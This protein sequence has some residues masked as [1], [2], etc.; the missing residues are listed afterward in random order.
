MIIS[1][2]LTPT[3]V[4]V[5][6]TEI[7]RQEPLRL[8]ISLAEAWPWPGLI[9]RAAVRLGSTLIRLRKLQPHDDG[10]R[11]HGVLLETDPVDALI[12]RTL[13]TLP[14]VDGVAYRA[15][16]AHFAPILALVRR[17]SAN[18]VVR[19]TERLAGCGVLRL[20]PLPALSLERLP[21]DGAWHLRAVPAF[22]DPDTEKDLGWPVLRAGGWW[23]FAAAIAPAPEPFE[24]A[25]LRALFED[26]ARDLA[27]E[28]AL[29]FAATAT[30]TPGLKLLLPEELAHAVR[31]LRAGRKVKAQGAPAA[32]RVTAPV[33]VAAS[34]RPADEAGTETPPPPANSPWNIYTQDE[35][36]GAQ[37]VHDELD[38]LRLNLTHELDAQ[39]AWFALSS[40]PSEEARALSEQEIARLMRLRK[41]WL[42]QNGP[43]PCAPDRAAHGRRWGFGGEG[44]SGLVAEAREH[45]RS[46]FSLAGTA[47]H[48]EQYKAFLER[49]KTFQEVEA[50]P[51]PAGFRM[52][53]RPY[54]Q[55][56]YQWLCFLAKYGLNGILADEM[57]LGKTAQTLAM[58]AARREA[59][60][61]W[62][63]LIV[64]PTSLVDNWAAE[65]L[66]FTPQLRVLRYRGSPARRDRLRKL[67]PERDI[68][69]ATYA[70]VRNDAAL[71]KD[72]Q[73]R[74]VILDEAHT[75]KNA[76]AA[77]TKAIK[78]IPARHRLALT[79]TPVQNRLD[80]LWSLFDFLMPGYLARRS[81]FFRE[82]E[83]PIVKGQGPGAGRKDAEQGQRAAELLRERIGPFILRRLKSEVAKDL[84]E[85]IEQD[86]PCRLTLD[87]VAL[88]RQF[89]QSEEARTAVRELE[90]KGVGPAQ[91]QILAALTSLRKI[92]NHPDLI[93]LSKEVSDGKK[94]VPLPGYEARAGKLSALADLLDQCRAGGHRAL[95][96][97]QL[98]SMLDIL[99]H[100]LVARRDRFLRLD[101]STP[102][103]SRQGLVDR[104]NGDPALLAFLISTRAGGSGLNLTGADTV[105]FYD[106]DWNPANDRQAQ[107]RAYRIGQKRVVNV[108][109]L[110]TQGTLEEK[111]L[112]RQ[113]LK[114]DLADAVVRHDAGGFKDLSREELLGLFTYT[115]A[116]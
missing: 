114:Q 7:A 76:A 107:D 112:A 1:D 35:A 97:C 42:R 60:G 4:D 50:A 5:P 109:R 81:V 19:E 84:P 78:T 43:L 34:A 47:Q 26:G 46:L 65:T 110:V 70:T 104:F 74:Y 6:D 58:L 9:V 45:V 95:I 82:Y 75:I 55:H 38:D 8:E 93:Y 2:L 72:E 11:C 53:L 14:T 103:T 13:L 28:E 33:P 105:I 22:R 48:A 102:P 57:G 15:T 21:S 3:G 71:L 62:P 36:E 92:C 101:G 40:N 59:E 17:A 69:L 25:T 12:V 100:F 108:Y 18:T 94:I 37:L 10:F 113:A 85:K 52:P 16:G 63:A 91:V 106:H 39:E 96:F 116:G 83:E 73:W 51:L 77:T 24:D 32:V 20:A 67:I 56:G 68:V 98:T 80:E 27:G 30:E 90:E 86:I 61:V 66:K 31:K 29:A 54:Q 23:T 87:Q 88:Y 41:Q 44:F 79:G 111:I 49:L 99:E 64:C 89:G 115:P